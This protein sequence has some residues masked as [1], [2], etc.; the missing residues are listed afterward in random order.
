MQEIDP[1]NKLA[2]DF[3]GGEKFFKQLIDAGVGDKDFIQEIVVMFVKEAEHTI[4]DLNESVNEK[5]LSG[6]KMNAHKLKSSFSMFDLTGILDLI[7]KLENL[8]E[9]SVNESDMI[10]A[11]L[12]SQASSAFKIIKLKYL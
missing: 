11:D 3:T 7:K 2:N 8:T 6:I 4:H 1:D 12:A 10:F 9:G 5:N